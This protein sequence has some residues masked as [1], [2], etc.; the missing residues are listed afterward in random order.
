MIPPPMYPR[1][2]HLVA[3]AGMDPDDLVL[4]EQGRECLLSHPVIAEEK[5]DGANMSIWIENDVPRVGTRGGPNTIDRSG[6]RGRARAWAA[7]HAD[8]LQS[9]LGDRYAIYAEWLLRRQRVHY[10]R[11][12]APLVGIDVFDRKNGRFLRLPERDAVLAA[13]GIATPPILFTGSLES[14]RKAKSLIGTTAYGADR[15]EGIVITTLE[16]YDGCP[17]VA[18]LIGSN[19]QGRRDTDWERGAEENVVIAR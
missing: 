13:A 8:E 5:L 10:E 1:I 14:V 16:P 15:A 11:L 6:Q 2:P 18:K 19:W 4:G 3:T 9:A 7:E 12:P 17:R